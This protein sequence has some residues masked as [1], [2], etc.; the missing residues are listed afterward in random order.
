MSKQ[1]KKYR[2]KSFDSIKEFLTQKNVLPIRS[3]LTYHYYGQQ[4]TNNVT[5]LVQYADKQEIHILE[6]SDGLFSLKEIIPVST[7]KE[8]FSW[9]RSHGFKEIG[10]VKMESQT[11]D[12][13][14]GLVRLYLIDDWLHAIILSHVGDNL[15]QVEA[16]LGLDSEEVI[17]QPFNVYLDLI[18]KLKISEI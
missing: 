15:L 7:K 5:K 18:G 8:G 12:Y 1:E 9:L 2:I 13:S 4:D 16:E 10:E 11:F 3:S 17:S 6:E 14:E